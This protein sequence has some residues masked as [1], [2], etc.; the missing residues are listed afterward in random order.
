MK[1]NNVDFPKYVQT[2]G[3]ITVLTAITGFLVFIFAFAVDVGTKELSKVS[4][5]TATTTL[6]VLNTP[7]VFTTGAYEITESS[8]STPTNSGDLIEWAAVGS[9]ANL[10]DYYLLICSSNASPTPNM[11]AAPACGVPA[12]LWGVSTATVSGA[13]AYVAT[14][15]TETSP[16]AEVNT[17]F[18]WVCD[19]DPS[20]P[21]CSI[22]P[23]QG[24]NATNS[25]PFI[26]N[27]EPVL[28][29]ATNDGPADP[30]E[31]INFTTTS[32][33]SDSFGGEDELFIVV[34]NSIGFS[35]TTK[36]CTGTEIASSTVGTTDN[37][38]T[39]YTLPSIIRDDTY[40]AFTYIYDEHGH[41]AG[42]SPIQNDFIVSNV[43]PVVVGGDIVLNGGND[44]SLTI[45]AG[46]TTGFS[47]DFTIRDA[48]SCVNAGGGD[49]ITDYSVAIFRSGIGTSTCDTSGAGYDPN[50]CYDSGVGT[51]TWNLSCVATTTCAGA[52]QDNLD[53]TC[54]FPLWF[55]A[56]PTD[57]GPNTPALLAGDTWSAAVS[58]TDD[59]AATGPLAT[60]S[61]PVELISFNSIQIL[62]NDIAYGG[63]EPGQDTGSLFAT[64][65][66]ENVG[67]TGIDQI[68]LGDSMCIGYDPGTPCGGDVTSTIPENRQQFASST[69][70]YNSP[71]ALTL[72]STTNQ[73]L[74]LDV[75][76]TTSTTSY[77]TAVTYWGISVPAAITVA[78]DYTGMNTFSA[79]TAEPVDW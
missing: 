76:K 6:T 63:I 64:S 70:T 77:Q 52:L 43:S 35:T 60:T 7:P 49:E 48:N 30:G 44:M 36:T 71:A 51:T 55:L 69:L 62:A 59:D 11:N 10:A 39:T 58:G 27:S 1:Y 74:E 29:G 66:L 32:S 75:N 4:A 46:E 78:G 37:A 19:A 28:S 42:A 17:W 41:L 67:N 21:R 53:F 79:V 57:P 25:S 26:V 40:P 24:L 65:T 2:A 22:T 31:N 9:D 38:S 14:T 61:S 68:V 45:P 56:D 72:S 12:D 54:N 23:V 8:S 34:C 16:F 20:A 13:P 5:Q 50:N 47:L 18:A 15:T 73:E 3:K 33:D